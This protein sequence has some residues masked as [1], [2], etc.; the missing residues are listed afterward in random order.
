MQIQEVFDVAAPPEAVWAF[1]ERVERVAHC[2]PGV[3][4]VDVQGPERYKIVASQKV[5]FITATFELTTEVAGREAGRFMEFTS[6]GKSVA[7][8]VGHLRSRDR[9]D[10]EPIA[11]GHPGAPHLGAGRGRHAGGARPQGRGRQVSRD[12]RAVRRRPARRLASERG[13]D[14]RVRRLLRAP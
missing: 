6:V 10:F 9:V 11:G 3:K 2:V 13:R 5:G 14:L 1:F 12:H 8:A 4:S 7:G